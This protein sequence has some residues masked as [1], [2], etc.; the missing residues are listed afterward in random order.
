[1]TDGPTFRDEPTAAGILVPTA[2]DGI[3]GRSSVY[4]GIVAVDR[5][6]CE[7]DGFLRGVGALPI[8]SRYAAERFGAVRLLLFFPDMIGSVSVFRA[9]TLTTSG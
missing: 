6:P 3:Y 2:S 1:M 8:P 4:E 9:T 7:R 5:E